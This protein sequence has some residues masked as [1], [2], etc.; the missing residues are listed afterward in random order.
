MIKFHEIK[1]GDLV[2]AEFEGKQTEGIVKDLNRED[3]EVCI[4]TD[5]Q[6]FWFTPNHLNP[7]PLSDRHLSKLGFTKQA[8]TDGSAKYS[9]GSFRILLPRD[10]DFSEIEIWWREDRRHLL[11]PIHVHELQ[12]HYY[13][14]TKV[15]LNED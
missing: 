11:K 7:I 4:E 5:V 9:K 8:N 12:N 14:M 6:E 2:L 13:Q 1:V 3:K 10:G 15:E